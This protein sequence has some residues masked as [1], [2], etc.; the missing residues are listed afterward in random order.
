MDTVERT[1]LIA[2]RSLVGNTDQ[3]ERCQVTLREQ[4]A[5]QRLMAQLGTSLFPSTRRANLLL[6]GTCLVNARNKILRI[7]M[8]R[9]RLLGEMEPC[10]R[11]D[12]AFPG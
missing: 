12:E 3:G 7:G 10:E 11:R 2:H 6:S 5:W 1:T 4:E 8:C 9:I